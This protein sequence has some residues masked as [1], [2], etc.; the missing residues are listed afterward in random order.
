MV[1]LN[2]HQALPG[3]G[4]GESPQ[5]PVP[6]YHLMAQQR[7]QVG[8]QMRSLARASHGGSVPNT[9]RGGHG[10]VTGSHA[11]HPWESKPPSL[12]RMVTVTALGAK[13]TKSLANRFPRA[14]TRSQ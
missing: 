8:E 1:R 9:A 7:T 4:Q 14:L 12:A 5:H 13:V 6:C 11:P 10:G 3:T 2:A